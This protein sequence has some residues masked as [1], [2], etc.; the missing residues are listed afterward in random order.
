MNE[1][2]QKQTIVIFGETYSVVSDESP[3]KMKDAI[4]LVDELMSVIA[5][6]THNQDAKR[7]AVLCALQL[8]LECGQLKAAVA[9]AQNRQEALARVLDRALTTSA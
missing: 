7:C 2:L 1:A 8:A 5:S 3:Q 4:A 6:Q 9:Q